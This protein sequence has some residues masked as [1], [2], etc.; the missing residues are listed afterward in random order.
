[1][2]TK[3]TASKQF[4]L[5]LPANNEVV[6]EFTKHALKR[7]KQRFVDPFALLNRL[8]VTPRRYWRSRCGVVAKWQAKTRSA[9]IVTVWIPGE[10]DE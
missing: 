8:A 3:I 9:L 7:C 2:F 10:N 4:A 5:R 6:V 1:M